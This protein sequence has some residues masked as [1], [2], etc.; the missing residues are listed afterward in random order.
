MR[1]N[2]FHALVDRPFIEQ[3][4][5]RAIISP[6]WWSMNTGDGYRAYEESLQTYPRIQRVFAALRWYKSEVD[7]GGHDQLFWNST[8]IVWSDALEA[9]RLLG[10]SGFAAILEESIRRMGGEPPAR[11]EDRQRILEELAPSFDDLDRQFYRLDKR[12]QLEDRMTAYMRRHAEAFL[13]DGLIER[14]EL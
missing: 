3:N 1:M 11:Q 2:I 13:F 9:L 14:P 10:Q 7:N 8:G 6:A 5:A 4:D 12:V